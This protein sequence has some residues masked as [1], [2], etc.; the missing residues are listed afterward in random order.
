MAAMKDNNKTYKTIGVF[1]NI[2]CITANKRV[3]IVT[4]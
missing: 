4:E 1:E 3:G 2:L